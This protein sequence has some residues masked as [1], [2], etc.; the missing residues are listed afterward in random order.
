MDQRGHAAHLNLVE[1]SQRLFELDS[2]A[3]VEAG[4][5]WLFGAGTAT[6]PVISNAAFRLDDRLDPDEL[7]E[8]ARRF[9]GARGRAFAV[10]ARASAEED[11]DLVAALERGG[12]RKVFAMP[13]MVLDR[14]PDLCPRPAGVELRRVSSPRDAEDYWKV[15]VDAYAT[16][17][18]P[19]EVFA[20]YD[21]HDGL[22]AD[23][24]T[25][26]LA[27]LDCRPAS[28]AM[29]IV[30]HGVAGIYWV[31]TCQDARGHGL[32]AMVTTA[33]VEAGFEAGCDLVSLQAS[34]LG[35]PIYERMGF[36][37]IHDY[38][39]YLFQQRQVSNQGPQNI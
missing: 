36:E 35:R 26:F 18:F 17:G 5:G 12:L 13:E 39:L 10:W 9:F 23:G 33:A 11:R 28:I 15:A 38:E 37:A 8:R 1:S 22:W 21:R 3:A 2:G 27:L 29:A 24:A 20:F 31:G 19:E 32:G 7:L 14:R 34:P 30:N 4:D 6:H 25:A 16:N